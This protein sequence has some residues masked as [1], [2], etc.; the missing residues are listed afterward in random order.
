MGTIMI[1]PSSASTPA[2]SMVRKPLAAS[3]VDS[4]ISRSARCA[5]TTSRGRPAEQDQPRQP[6]AERRQRRHGEQ[7]TDEQARSDQGRQGQPA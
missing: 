4:G 5:L 1:A 6:G 3:I 2:V 7:D